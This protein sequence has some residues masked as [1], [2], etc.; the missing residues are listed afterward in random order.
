MH[1]EYNW[2]VRA[3]DTDFSGLVYTPAVIDQVIRR[4]EAFRQHAGLAHEFFTEHGLI[5]PTV[6]VEANYR[7]PVRLEDDVVLTLAP[8]IGRTSVVFR[9]EGRV[10]GREAFDVRLTNVVTDRQ[11]LRP[12]AVPDEVRERLQ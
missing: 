12:V 1:R 4:V 5:L 8:E 3:G 11:T 7:S 2:T 10:D 9:A 6:N